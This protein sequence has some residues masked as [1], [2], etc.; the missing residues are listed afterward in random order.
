MRSFLPPLRFIF[1]RCFCLFLRSWIRQQ[2]QAD[3][4]FIIALIFG[5]ERD[6]GNHRRGCN[7]AVGDE[8]AV[9]NR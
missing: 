7:Q 2:I 1:T 8:Q 5:H 3:D 9:A 6:T 4:E